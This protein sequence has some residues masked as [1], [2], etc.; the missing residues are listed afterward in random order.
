MKHFMDLA[1]P[2]NQTVAVFGYG[3]GEVHPFG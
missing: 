2:Q 3:S 1:C